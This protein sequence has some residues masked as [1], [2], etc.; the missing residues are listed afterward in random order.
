MRDFRLT[1]H[2]STFSS[3]FD[4]SRKALGMFKASTA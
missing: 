4:E 2:P 3:S 1:V